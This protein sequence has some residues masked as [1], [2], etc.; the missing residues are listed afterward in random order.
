MEMC[1]FT[2]MNKLMHGFFPCLP[3]LDRDKVQVS[4][5]RQVRGAN[6]NDMTQILMAARR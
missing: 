3:L 1:A 4:K 6:P 2:R 5:V